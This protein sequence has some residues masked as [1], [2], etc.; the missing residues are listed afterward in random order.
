MNIYEIIANINWLGRKRQKEKDYKKRIELA[1]EIKRKIEKI[2]EILPGD[3]DLMTKLMFANITLDL[4]DDAQKIGDQLLEKGIKT[5][6]VLQG[7]AIIA[8]KN[9]NYQEALLFLKQI[10]EKEPDNEYMLM[11]IQ[12]VEAKQNKKE[13][14]SRQSQSKQYKREKRNDDSQSKQYKYRQIADLERQIRKLAEKGQEEAVM[15]RFK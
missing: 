10:V 4:Y 5:R 12:K 14:R 8:E 7:M 3:S 6:D 1:K 11:R 13:E 15:R 9:E 2:L